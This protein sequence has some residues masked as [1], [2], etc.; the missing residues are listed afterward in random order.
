MT[1]E[2][3]VF[4]QPARSGL[5]NTQNYSFRPRRKSFWIAG[6]KSVRI[7]RFPRSK[8][9]VVDLTDVSRAGHIALYKK[10]VARSPRSGPF[11]EMTVISIF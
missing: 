1:Q 10:F 8:S 6:E 5:K 4:Q 7:H 11:G 2:N 3:I 9:R